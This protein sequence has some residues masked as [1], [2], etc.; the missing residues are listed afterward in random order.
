M[1][2]DGRFGLKFLPNSF[3][4]RVMPPLLTASCSTAN[5]IVIKFSVSNLRF[6]M[7]TSEAVSPSTSQS[8]LLIRKCFI[9]PYWLDICILGIYS[10]YEVD[11]M[12]LTFW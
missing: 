6:L 2:M 7:V 1:T 10:V 12:H 4:K 9:I 8:I 3:P 5:R 11:I